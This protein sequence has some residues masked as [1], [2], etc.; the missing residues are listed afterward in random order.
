[1]SSTTTFKH[2]FYYCEP[3]AAVLNYD[4]WKR[5]FSILGG[6]FLTIIAVTTPIGLVAENLPKPSLSWAIT[7]FVSW[8][9]TAIAIVWVVVPWLTRKIM[10]VENGP[11]PSN[12][13]GREPA[14]QYRGTASYYNL[15]G[16]DSHI[17]A[18]LRPEWYWKFVDANLTLVSDDIYKKATGQDRQRPF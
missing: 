8:I 14:A 12:A 7:A 18:A 16:K 6:L 11:L 4:K 3:C 2:T 9:F 1:M 17:F 5:P 13:L 15:S 10:K